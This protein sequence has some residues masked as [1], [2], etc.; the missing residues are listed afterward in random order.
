MTWFGFDY[1]EIIQL[2]KEE[3]KNLYYNKINCF[4]NVEE[5]NERNTKLF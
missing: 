5:T 3:L 1:M 4:K 2:S